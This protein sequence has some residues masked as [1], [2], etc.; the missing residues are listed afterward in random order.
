LELGV[1][2]R[3]DVGDRGGC[4]VL[5]TQS[6]LEL[7]GGVGDTDGTVDAACPGELVAELE[8]GALGVGSALTEKVGGAAAV[9]EELA[10]ERA[11]TEGR[12]TLDEGVFLGHADLEAVGDDAVLVVDLGRSGTRGT[13]HQAEDSG[14]G[15]G[16]V[17]SGLEA[18]RLDSHDYSVCGGGIYCGMARSRTR[19]SRPGRRW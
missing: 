16:G 13:E 15:D 14:A 3:K 9:V 19:G 7:R 12:N 5:G 6:D 2:L 8:G 18:T 4:A 17:T 10:V 11:A 1:G